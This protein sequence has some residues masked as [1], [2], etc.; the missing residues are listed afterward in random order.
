M[1][2][3][4]TVW[5]LL[6]P[7]AAIVAWQRGRSPSAF[8]VLA[9]LLSPIISIG[10]ALVLAPNRAVIEA[11]EL[12]WGK[13]QKCP[14]CAELI[15]TEANVCRYCGTKLARLNSTPEAQLTRR[16]FLN[17]FLPADSRFHEFVY[18]YDV[19]IVVAALT[20]LLVAVVLIFH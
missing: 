8:F 15:R 3:L 1:I 19:M 20:L 18:Q 10:V 12:R 7:V 17:P 13:T 6:S 9:I 14:S 5:L 2:S 4:V 11:R 16:S